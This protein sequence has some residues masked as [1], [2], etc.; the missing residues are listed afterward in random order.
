ML[1]RRAQDKVHKQAYKWVGPRRITKVLSGLVYEVEH[2]L[3]HT[4]EQV[5]AARMKL[6]RVSKDG[7]QVSK[8]LLEH[9]ECSEARYE[10]V[11]KLMDISGNKKEGIFVQVKWLGL[12]DNQDWTW[13]SIKDL[14]EDIPH[15]L[16]EFLRNTKKKRLAKQAGEKIG[17]SL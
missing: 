15:K 6:Y 2:L 17:M 4:I 8:E 16:E 11:D 14:Q 10:I 9:V 13:H 12:P 5:Y 3:T 7:A 1:I